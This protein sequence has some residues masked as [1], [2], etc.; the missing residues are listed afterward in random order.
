MTSEG[1]W[2]IGLQEDS[3]QVYD[4]TSKFSA[5]WKRSRESPSEAEEQPLGTLMWDSPLYAGIPL[6]NKEAALGLL[7]GRIVQDGNSK[8]RD[9]ERVGR[10]GEKPWSH[11]RKQ[12]QETDSTVWNLAGMPQPRG[13]IQIKR[14]G[15]I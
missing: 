6:V 1:I 15:L 12:M 11:Q 9:E 4:S 10:V 7:Q 2:Q 13:N 8:Q 14:N 5:L 3:F